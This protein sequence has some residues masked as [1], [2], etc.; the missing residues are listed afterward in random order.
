MIR[1]CKLIFIALLVTGVSGYFFWGRQSSSPLK[2]EAL[3]VIA[4]TQIIEHHTLDTVRAG[5]MAE[6]AENGFDE[7]TARIVYENAY[8]NVATATQIGSKF[9]ALHP[10]NM[11]A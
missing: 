10:K 8:G 7:K 6:L 2:D 11:V 4:L 9:A 1:P 5:L 3:P